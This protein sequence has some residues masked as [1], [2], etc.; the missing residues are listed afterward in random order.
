MLHVY[1]SNR[2]EILAQRLSSLCSE[3][4]L[5]ALA[6]ETVVVPNVGVGRWL[7]LRL[8]DAAGICA[9]VQ[10]QLPGAHAW[11][12]FR[13]LF[14]DL[15]EH[16]P[17][18]RGVLAWRLLAI[19]SRGPTG[20]AEPDH[21]L[22]AA[23]P[24]MRFEFA[25][26][27]AELFDQYLVYRPDWVRDWEA[28]EV[29]AQ[30]W[31]GRLWREL[32]GAAPDMHW[33]RLLERTATALAGADAG[34]R[35]PA[36]SIVFGVAAL[37]PTY[38]QLLAAVARVSDV[39]L[40]APNPC[41]E[42]WADIIAERD[43][44]RVALLGEETGHY[45][46]GNPLLS[47]LGKQ[48]R[49]FFGMLAALEGESH[50]LFQAPPTDTTLGRLQGEILA[51]AAPGSLAGAPAAD[52]ASI[53]LHACH[54]PLRELEVLQDALLDLFQSRPGLTP[55]DVLVMSPDIGA[56]A[57]LVEAVFGE[58]PARRRIPC[59]VLDAGSVEAGGVA[60]TFEQLLATAAGRM[61]AT[62]VLELLEC[63]ALRRRFGLAAEDVGRIRS[64]VSD[65]GIRWGLD[66]A[67]RAGFGLPPES[68]NSWR[69][70]LDAML[71][72]QATGPLPDPFAGILAYPHIEGDGTRVLG[73]L[74]RLLETLARLG[75]QLAEP[76]APAR[77][78]AL[79]L[80]LLARCFEPA[81]EE[82]AEL[83]AVREAVNGV[84]D[85]AALAGFEA[86]V[87]IKV[88]MAGVSERL[89]QTG[90]GAGFPAGAVSFC[91]MV[92]LRSVPFRVICLI[93]MNDD[94]FPRRQPQSGFDRMQREPR[95]GDRS[96]REDDRYLFLEA[97]LSARETLYISWVGQHIRTGEERPPS[98]L[99]SE[100]MDYLGR[101]NG[102]APPV[103]RHP[104]QPF[105]RRYFS[106]EAGLFSHREDL[107]AAL[108]SRAGGAREPVALAP[109]SQPLPTATGSADTGLTL[110]ALQAFLR[111][112]SRAFVQAMGI[113][114]PG[115][116]PP[117]ADYEPFLLD[118]LERWSVG[119]TLLEA[120]QAGEALPAISERLRASGRLPHG[121]A[122]QLQLEQ[123]QRTQA[124][125][126]AALDARS[127]G[128]PLPPLAFR[129]ALDGLVLGGELAP[130]RRSGLA[131]A[132]AG[133]RL[134]GR[135]LLP[136]WAAHLV[137]NALAPAGV[138]PRTTIVGVEEQAG[139]I[140]LPPD[141][142]LAQL[143]Q[144]ARLYMAAQRQPLPLFPATTLVFA[145]AMAKTGDVAAALEAA[146]A[147]WQGNEHVPG[148]G[149]DPWVRYL[150]R[151]SLPLDAR[152][153]S[154]AERCCLSLLDAL[155]P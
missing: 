50:E 77:W 56:H 67:H 117:L 75:R 74:S 138:D 49:E 22:A 46:T 105:S 20:F 144:L 70:G 104:L 129:L 36:R 121:L 92:P 57:P 76:A 39:H 146:T 38:L 90:S 32:A 142:A 152:F 3:Q 44:G 147:E 47:S 130:L 85:E 95:T 6:P 11:S 124:G 122:G 1:Q 31:Q 30:D 73:A 88:F 4:P 150:Y 128:E 79:L 107:C 52:D 37:S 42:F 83:A 17:F 137:L 27:L 24:G 133:K 101:M 82:E 40:F 64:W 126:V 98:V 148:E 110:P 48:G 153:Q 61:S 113:R 145:R 7:K 23:D 9:N 12:L 131:L 33:V 72:G 26:R 134:G 149:S 109:L 123:L 69:A 120:M 34:A 112:P 19:L 68:A 86:A 62:A 71:L 8:A 29:E 125:V 65:T 155:A 114:L 118:G 55:G 21:Y 35:L 106:G 151:D 43:L 45:D 53:A 127:P 96:R 94:A 140:P 93:G 80:D 87:P 119:D 14:D 2:V 66:A 91:S 136:A 116:E 58:A 63:A 25:V 5:N 108:R 15:P 97:L 41:A 139:F 89:A 81:L 99:V 115:E 143:N 154:L 51:L 100:L 78:A 111:N 54:S 10:C 18:D 84:A 59:T 103:R 141:E 16:S 135:A 13:R 132:R 102:A 60:V 28:G